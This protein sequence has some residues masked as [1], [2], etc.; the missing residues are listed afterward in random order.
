[1]YKIFF[2]LLLLF[3]VSSSYGQYVSGVTVPDKSKPVVSDPLDIQSRCAKSISAATLRDHL[4]ILASDSLQGRETGQK[5]M[6]MA[7]DYISNYIYNLG[8]KGLFNSTAFQQNI[9]FTY[10]KWADT[11]IYVNKER[12]RHLWDYLA[13][14]DKNESQKAIITNEVMFLGYGIDDPK[15]SDYKNVD[16]KDKVILIN[17]GEPL[18]KDSTSYITDAKSL[19]EWSNQD[20]EKKL[21]LAKERGVKLVLII[22][23]DIKKLL[24]L[25]R[26][27]LLGSFMELG[28]T[29]DKKLVY[30]NNVYISSTVAKAII[31]TYEKKILKARKKMSKGKPMN[32]VMSTDM[33]INLFKGATLLEGK[34][35]I[36][37]IEG[38]SKKDEYV[39]VSAHYDHLGKKGDEIFN[40]ADDNGSG[41]STLMELAKA[42]QQAVLEGSQPERSVVFIWFC[43]EEKGLLGS[44]YYTQNPPFPLNQTMVDINI[45]MVGRIDEKY[46]GNPD[47]IYLIGSDRLSSD[48]HK[49]SEDVNQK[50]VQM[51]L[52]Y[53]Y[54]SEDDPNKFY[55]RSDHYNFAKNGIPAIFY[56]NGT[57]SDYHQT[58]DDVEKINFEAME[59][60]G[61][62]IFHTIWE[63]ANRAEKIRVDG[64][65]K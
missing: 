52:D 37:L 24:E 44:E 40:G 7:S 50:Y 10:S 6:E 17:R 20:M 12:F 2:I 62:L 34:N 61:K 3:F 22:E 27:K 28:N 1:M 14:P 11:D 43:G 59:K 65:F 25:N 36:G 41:S 45:D 29:K 64:I 48:L 21:I 32:V 33:V 8:L 63:L 54:N 23:N 49:I 9:A 5:G 51:T 35:V 30:P 18:K 19:S 55:Y 16:V 13:L 57:H 53:T 56:F 26:K 4:R 42:F 58:T 31:G 46:A 60:R 39:I 47:Y 15:Y 38:K